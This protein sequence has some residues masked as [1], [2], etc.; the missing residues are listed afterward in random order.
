[1]LFHQVV[2]GL[3]SRRRG[4]HL[5]TD[6]ILAAVP[7]I[8]QVRVGLLNL[9]LRH[10]SASLFLNENA[11]PDVRTD[12]ETWA[13]RVIPDG[14]KEFVHQL[15]GS[16]DMPAHVKCALFGA[17][18]TLP[19]REGQ[20]ALGTWQGIYLGEHREHGGSRNVVATLWGQ[21]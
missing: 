19:V 2:F 14:A 9:L 17:Q 18:L 5:V 8:R 20:L 12:L 21:D 4:F 3:A 16:D 6:E 13:R 11:D 7:Q 10:T 1:M 15:E